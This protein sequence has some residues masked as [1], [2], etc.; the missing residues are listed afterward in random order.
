MFYLEIRVL[1]G[2]APQI[3]FHLCFSCPIPPFPILP[4]RFLTPMSL[5]KASPWREETIS[6]E[7]I[8]AVIW[9][10]YVLKKQQSASIE[11]ERRS[12]HEHEGFIFFFCWC[13][14]KF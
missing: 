10:G 3:G 14:T 13:L 11:A 12:L 5:E 2:L 4:F 1:L 9:Y 6:K 7:D 8:Y